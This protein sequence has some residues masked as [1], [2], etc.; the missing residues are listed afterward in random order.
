MAVSITTTVDGA[1]SL[2]L[3]GSFSDFVEVVGFNADRV[4]SVE[5]GADESLIVV[6]LSAEVALL[7]VADDL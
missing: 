4:G 6:D 5:L 1:T 2:A 3:I 7:S